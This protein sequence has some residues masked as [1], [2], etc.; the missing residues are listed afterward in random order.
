MID[1]E[2]DL[3]NL[4]IRTKEEL[5]YHLDKILNEAYNEGCISIRIITGKGN[6]SK[7]R[8]LLKPLTNSYLKNHKLVS[9]Y[10]LDL[11]LGS[12]EIYLIN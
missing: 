3:H 4:N 5:L 7:D 2:Y 11:S 8:P 6:N 1:R 10:K 12:F 9:S